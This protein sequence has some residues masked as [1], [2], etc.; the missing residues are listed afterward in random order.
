MLSFV[1]FNKFY[2]VKTSNLNFNNKIIARELNSLF[3]LYVYTGQAHT[4][5]YNT[6]R[7]QP[8]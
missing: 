8:F 6:L 5:F 7:F 3:I 2:Y 4:D 1:I